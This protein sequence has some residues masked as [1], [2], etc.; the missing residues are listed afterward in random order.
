M[1]VLQR[2]KPQA[3]ARLNLLCFPYAGGGAS[4]FRRW[5]AA[6]GPAIEVVTVQPPGRENR[7]RD[8]PYGEMEPLVREIL[9]ALR[10]SGSPFTERPMALFGHSFG[11]G[12]A[13][14]VAHELSAHGT[15]PALL[16]LS[17]RLPPHGAKQR[18]I[19]HL[20]DSHLVARLRNLG[21][22]PREVLEHKE[23]LQLLLPAFRADM[24]ILEHHLPN[25]ERPL[26]KCPVRVFGGREDPVAPAP[27]IEEWSRYAGPDFE[28]ELF[29][30]DHFYLHGE[31]EEALHRAIRREALAT[32]KTPSSAG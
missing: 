22:T 26:L 10:A 21:G 11:A 30:G 1:S 14:E 31:A 28:C 17:G 7:L 9:S 27:G 15:P 20:D 19:S 32:L 8:A 6:L 16:A 12:V 4:V 5:H 13:F 18:P 23:L 2:R 29:P 25:L 3:D 24:R